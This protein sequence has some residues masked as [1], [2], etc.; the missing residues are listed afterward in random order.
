MQ[1]IF[2]LFDFVLFLCAFHVEVGCILR[3]QE[4]D[5][6][7]IELAAVCFLGVDAGLPMRDDVR[8]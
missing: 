2:Q 5:F 7:T 4:L 8:E 3:L 1:V 6:I